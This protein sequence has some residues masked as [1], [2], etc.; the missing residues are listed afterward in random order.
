[1]ASAGLSL[2][3]DAASLYPAFAA[4]RGWRAA[5]DM[6]RALKADRLMLPKQW[7]ASVH[8]L[9]D[10]FRREA[11]WGGGGIT[12]NVLQAISENQEL[13]YA[14]PI[15]GTGERIGDAMIACLL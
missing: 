13:R 2:L 6:Q 5:A 11:V 3:L 14:I 12:G 10:G 4:Y 15:W 8:A 9:R 1:V 7:D